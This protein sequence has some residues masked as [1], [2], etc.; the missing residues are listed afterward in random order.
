M[1]VLSRPSLAV[2]DGVAASITVGNSIPIVGDIITDPVNGSRTSVEYLQ[3]G[4]DLQVT[5]TVN[6]QGVVLMEITQSISNQA[7]SSGAEG[8]PIIFERSLQTEV[9]AGN[10]QTIMLGGLISENSTLSDRRVP[11]F[12]SIPIFGRLFD[13]TDNNTNKTELVV[14]VTPRI[15]DSTAEWESIYSEFKQGMSELK[16]SDTEGK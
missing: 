11:F 16:L 14:L 2:R 7:S 13:G 9:I 10:G 5:P 6:A 12:S 1:N 15:V 4:I 3:T 8:N